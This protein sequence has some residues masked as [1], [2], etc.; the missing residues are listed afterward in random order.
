VQQKFIINF[1]VSD[2]VKIHEG[3]GRAGGLATR[4]PRR[5]TAWGELGMSAGCCRKGGLSHEDE[6]EAEAERWR[7]SRLWGG[8]TYGNVYA[9][10]VVQHAGRCLRAG[11][12]HPLFHCD[13]PRHLPSYYSFVGAGG[14]RSHLLEIVCPALRRA[15]LS[16]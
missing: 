9:T 6:D 13:Q 15:L 5:T 14:W 3:I 1:W 4:N 7:G 11:R 12:E 16:S 2:K 10:P 8:A